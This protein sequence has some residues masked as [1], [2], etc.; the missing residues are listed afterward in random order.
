MNAMHGAGIIHRDISPDN[1]MLLNSGQVKL[2]DL[3][4]ARDAGKEHTMTVMLKH[5][6]TPMEQYTGYNQG[7]WTD[8]Y[9]LCATLYHC[10]T[11]RTPPRAL[12][13]MTAQDPL[14]PPNRLGAALPLE[15]EQ[16]LLRG[17]AVEPKNRWQSMAR[18]YAA[19]YGTIIKDFPWLPESLETEIISEPIPDLR[20]K[21][22]PRSTGPKKNLK[23]W[24]GIAAGC[25]AVL[26]LGC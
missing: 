20:E 17:L 8:V 15:Q 10:L 1:I 14:I 18:L 9:A 2:L 25:L 22:L 5:G 4:C 7:P 11:G 24:G 19:L 21:N 12:E 16:A 6:Y 26:I 13:R 3:G 23:L